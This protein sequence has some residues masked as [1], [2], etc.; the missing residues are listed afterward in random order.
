ME[1]AQKPDNKLFVVHPKN[2]REKVKKTLKNF[3][4]VEEVKGS[5]DLLLVRL[6]E[7]TAA[8]RKVLRSIQKKLGNAGVVHHVLIDEGGHHLYPTGEISVRFQHTPSDA[9]LKKF[10]AA[11]KL[12]LHSRNEYVPQQAIFEPV[13]LTD[14]DVLEL[15]EEVSQDKKTQLAWPNT[16]SHYDR[17]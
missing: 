17:I 2:D 1:S 8:P 4:D 3:G 12:R 14:R 16:L 10:A 11:H 6:P 13:N 9:E 15:V 7:E 5:D